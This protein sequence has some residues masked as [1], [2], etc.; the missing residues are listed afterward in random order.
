MRL[1]EACDESEEPGDDAEDDTDKGR[2]DIGD[3]EEEEIG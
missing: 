1:D 2:D 3:K